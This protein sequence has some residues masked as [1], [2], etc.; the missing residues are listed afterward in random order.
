MLLE[1][2][3]KNV[4]RPVVEFASLLRVLSVVSTVD[5]CDVEDSGSFVIVLGGPVVGDAVENSP[6]VKQKAYFLLVVTRLVFSQMPVI[7]ADLTMG[8]GLFAFI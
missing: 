1:F 2:D 5:G 8:Y 7:L 4:E 3:C 6:P